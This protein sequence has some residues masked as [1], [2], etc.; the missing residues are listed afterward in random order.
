[1]LGYQHTTI[2]PSHLT[3]MLEK[4]EANVTPLPNT[5]LTIGAI[6]K[7]WLER[8][9]NYPEGT[10]RI[11]CALR[12]NLLKPAISPRRKENLTRM[13]VTL[14]SGSDEYSR[15]FEFMGQ[16]MEKSSGIEIRIR[17]HPLIPLQP[18]LDT[19]PSR[20]RTLFETSA[21]QLVDDLEWADVVL[22]A[23]ASVGLEAV[24]Q[25]IPAIYLDLG[26]F[27]GT[28]SMHGW[29]EFKWSVRDPSEIIPT[30][31][32]IESMPDGEFQDRQEQGRQYAAT[33]FNSVTPEILKAFSE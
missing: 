14:S 32:V 23:S 24:A 26:D 12:Q 19:L 30:L 13:L 16:A 29:Y 20:F 5:V 2:N 33:Y 11:G 6:T 8:E 18:V 21:G 27:L 22:Y 7:G 31:Q 1:M 4:D 25:G 15:V 17:P 28:D 3:Y 9:A 10:L